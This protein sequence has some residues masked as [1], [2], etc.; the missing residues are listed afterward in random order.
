MKGIVIAAAAG[1]V[2]VFLLRRRRKKTRVQVIQERA[3]EVLEDVTRRISEMRNDARRASGRAR[4]RLNQ[5]AK[6]LEG[7]ERELR[8]RFNGLSTDARKLLDR[9][10]AG[11]R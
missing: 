9:A 11:A 10:R 7:Q 5:Q 8:K 3:D 2:I 4:K 1:L 6:T